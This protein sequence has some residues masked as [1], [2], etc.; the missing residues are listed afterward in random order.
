MDAWHLGERQVTRVSRRLTA[1][2]GLCRSYASAQLWC[3]EACA[4]ES[5]VTAQTLLTCFSASARLSWNY[6]FSRLRCEDARLSCFTV[7]GMLTCFDARPRLCCSY[8][9]AQLWWNVRRDC[10]TGL[11]IRLCSINYS[12]SRKRRLAGAG[13]LFGCGRILVG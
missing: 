13:R 7:H 3:D 9:S 1:S 8:A 10:L 2:T 4:S 5:C 6:A 12:V 11:S